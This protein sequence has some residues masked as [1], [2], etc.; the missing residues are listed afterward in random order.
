MG[1]QMYLNQSGQLELLYKILFKT[2]EMALLFH[3]FTSS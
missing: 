2:T 1:M 3:S